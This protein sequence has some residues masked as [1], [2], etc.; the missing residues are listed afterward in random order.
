MKKNTY[1]DLNYDF[2][3]VKTI[4]IEEALTEEDLEEGLEPMIFDI[5]AQKSLSA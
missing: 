4:F 3:E 5:I 1:Y 2:R